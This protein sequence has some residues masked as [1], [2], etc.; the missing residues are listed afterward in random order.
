MKVSSL[1]GTLILKRTFSTSTMTA[2][3]FSPTALGP[4]VKAHTA[5][6]E[7]SADGAFKRTDAAWRNWIRNGKR[8]ALDDTYEAVES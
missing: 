2:Q 1:L 6:D 5:L 4:T 8:L 7:S 3:A